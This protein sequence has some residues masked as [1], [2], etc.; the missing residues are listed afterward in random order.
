MEVITEIQ[1]ANA[2]YVIRVTDQ[3]SFCVHFHYLR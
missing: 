3:R 1:D 2:L